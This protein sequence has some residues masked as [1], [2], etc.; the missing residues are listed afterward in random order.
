MKK[1]LFE[2]DDL[3]FR[4]LL[5]SDVDYL[6]QLDCDPEIKKFFPGGALTK[7]KIPEKLKEYQDKYNKYGY[8]C[9]LVFELKNDKF[10]GRAGMSDLDTGETEVG[11]LIV[12]ELWGKGFAT[13]IVKALLN[14]C[15]HN[16][17][18]DRVIAFTPVEHK[19]SERVM[20]KAGMRYLKKA[21]MPNV[22][23]E[24]VVYEYKFYYNSNLTD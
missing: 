1:Y 6:I 22:P 9:Y 18:K 4:P 10:I 5:D 20:Q 3:G 12:K 7:D 17:H 19:A 14:W 2:F 23:G 24:C 15:K 8:G 21:T 13:R 16:L 11:Y